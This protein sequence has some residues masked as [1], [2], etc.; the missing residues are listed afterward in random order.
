MRCKKADYVYH[1]LEGLE[2]KKVDISLIPK[3]LSYKVGELIKIEGTI[4]PQDIGLVD[5]EN[6]E[7]P[8]I[9]DFYFYDKNNFPNIAY[10]AFSLV[11]TEKELNSDR[12][13][14][15]IKYTYSIKKKGSYKIMNDTTFSSRNIYSLVFIRILSG[16]RKPRGYEGYVP[17]VFT[18]NNKTFI[19]IEVQ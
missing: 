16:K 4:T 14:Y 2:G 8:I 9:A 18:N 5:F 15:M 12:T 11:S 1:D 19:E 6:F 3:S 10:E 7:E 13:V 17:L